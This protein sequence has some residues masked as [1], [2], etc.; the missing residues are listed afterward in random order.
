MVHEH[1]VAS[2]RTHITNQSSM[3]MSMQTSF[4][5]E[6]VRGGEIVR[7]SRQATC[8]LITNVQIFNFGLWQQPQLLGTNAIEFCTVRSGCCV[9]DIC[10]KLMAE[11]RICLFDVDE[12]KRG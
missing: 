11:C 9:F 4:V 1:F 3:L 10:S 8:K 6:S 12:K 2:L 7:K 5:V